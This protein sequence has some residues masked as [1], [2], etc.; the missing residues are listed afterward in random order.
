[1][2][3]SQRIDDAPTLKTWLVGALVLLAPAAVYSYLRRHPNL[4][5]TFGTAD[6]HFVIVSA[7]A[8]T[9]LALAIVVGWTARQLPD[10]RT[11]ALSM[12]FLAMAGIF[13]AHGAGT[14]PF[15]HHHSPTTAASVAVAP[16]AGSAAYAQ[17]VAT[18][19]GWSK[20]APDP[21]YD[22]YTPAG[23]T[24]APPAGGH[25]GHQFS[26]APVST[27]PAAASPAKAV[28]DATS[29]A[30]LRAVGFSA[31][32]SLMVSALCFALA[33]VD[34]RRRVAD[35]IVRWWGA[36]AGAFVA[37]LVSYNVVALVYPTSM[38]WIPM[39]SDT[40]NWC[41][42]AV[43]WAGF[44]FAGF[45]F[46]QAYRIAGLPLQ[47]A[48]ALSMGLLCEA[49]WIMLRGVTW[50]LSWWQ[51][52]VIM[53]AG[54]LI[55]VIA[56]LRQ[57]RAAGDLGAVV[58]GLFLRQ[59]LAGL[60][61]GDPHALSALAAAVAAKDSETGEHTERVGD[62]AVAIGR[63]LGLTGERLILLRWAG[64]LHDL[65]KIGVPNSILRKPGKLTEEEFAVMKQHSPRGWRVALRSRT[66]AE[67]APII[68]AHHERL[69]GSG[70]PDGLTADQIPLEARIIAVADVWDALVCDR[71]YRAAMSYDE[72]TAILCKESGPHLDPL[73]VAAL[74]A[75]LESRHWSQVRRWG[76]R[77]A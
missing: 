52:H 12:A 65:G 5:P 72:A 11:F 76:N 60:R 14:G 68:R 24:P 54:F 62:L 56:L 6:G 40:V 50:H 16:P 35:F 33:V 34:L 36:L 73:C 23:Y 74:F 42:A 57:Y 45:R 27:E 3:R 38:N 7:V 15:Q 28:M 44:L 17:P 32:L 30:R 22:S 66:L 77:A 8:F 71:P 2:R 63:R 51:Y 37:L 19:R 55:P 9:A 18:P 61:S 70:Y 20:A 1:M 48:M 53:L 43:A 25:G 49:Q 4:D 39:K 47:G 21:A 13:V 10:E 69:D 31:R 41:V 59:S 46:L 26:G 67:A 58:E 29:I 75:E 64:R